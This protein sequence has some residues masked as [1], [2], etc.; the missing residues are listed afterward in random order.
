LLLAVLPINLCLAQVGPTGG[1]GG[2]RVGPP[3]P[4]PSGTGAVVVNSG[5][6][7][8]IVVSGDGTLNPST[9]AL[10]VRSTNGSSFAPVATS[11]SAGDLTTGTL[12]HARL[13]VLLSGDIPANAANTSGNAATAA[14]LSSAPALCPAGSYTLGINVT[15]NA[16]GCTALPVFPSAA[17]VG[18]TDTQTLTN[19][20]VDG[21][22]PTTFGFVD[23][24]SSIQTQLNGK[25]PL[26]VEPRFTTASFSAT[27][28]FTASSLSADTFKITLT[29]NVT[30]STLASA[31]TSEV[32]TWQIYEDGTGGR[33]FVFPT[34]IVGGCAISTAANTYTQIS[35]IFDGTNVIV[36]SC[37][38]NNPSVI[39]SGGTALGTASQPFQM[40]SFYGNGTYGTNSFTL[41]GTPTGNETITAYG[42]GNSVIPQVKD[43]TVTGG[44]VISKI[45]SDGSV[46]CTT[47]DGIVVG[48]GSGNSTVAGSSTVFFGIAG[49][50]TGGNAGESVKQI[51]WPFSGTFKT[52]YLLTN[53]SQPAGGALTCTWRV[54]G[55]DVSGGPGV[56]WAA[57]AGAGTQS[58]LTD[59][60]TVSAGNLVDMKCT[61]ASGS[62]SAAISGGTIVFYPN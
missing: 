34:N 62:N 3:G 59:S 16:Q 60:F 12:P 58:D 6:A 61:N 30:S 22:T 7:S 10:T 43:C 2:G 27:P 23:P 52:F 31:T 33:T 21:V 50:G 32:I 14:A 55:A 15:G 25:A 18:T 48:I 11:G 39:P 38:S 42:A 20:S 5:V 19:K 4:A 40:V 54:N 8:A 24:T 26:T 49:A 41:S 28:I 29:G 37:I 47:Q 9:G 17:I 36:R 1:G 57:S 51:P 56:S 46:T 13:P 45:N 53:T 44:Q 35:G